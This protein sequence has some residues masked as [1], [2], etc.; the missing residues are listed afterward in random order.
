MMPSPNDTE[1][2]FVWTFQP[3][4]TLRPALMRERR[5]EN[6]S[7][8]SIAFL[9]GND[10]MRARV[11]EAA[12]GWT[13]VGIG[14]RFLFVDD[15]TQAAARISFADKGRSWSLLGRECLEVTDTTQPTMNFGT[16]ELTS[17]DDLVRGTVL[18]EFGHL[19]GLLHEHQSPAHTIQWNKPR[20]YEDLS[21]PPWFWTPERIDH[22]LFEPF[23]AARVEATPFDPHSIMLYPIKSSW[24]LDGFSS[25][26]NRTLSEKDIDAIRRWYPCE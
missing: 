1:C 16:I 21:G 25:A 24:T 18:H 3:T 26:P 14:L 15:P 2:C 9:D 10:A 19:L 4:E 6:G 12:E 13:R 11:R 7:T 5:W 22:N 17:P 23:E 8:L 20:I